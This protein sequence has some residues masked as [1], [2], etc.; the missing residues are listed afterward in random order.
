MRI[1][2]DQRKSEKNKGDQ[3]H[4]RRRSDK[5]QKR[6]TT[7]IITR[8]RRRPYET[9]ENQSKSDEARRIQR[10]AEETRR[11]QRKS[12]KKETRLGEARERSKTRRSN[13]N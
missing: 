3:R 6:L 5:A 7:K 11:C 12:S 13:E 2:E 1:E 9:R 10:R 8:V 4:V